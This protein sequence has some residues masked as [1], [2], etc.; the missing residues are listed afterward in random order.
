V[1]NR[2]V[3]LFFPLAV[4]LGR[5]PDRAKHP[6]GRRSAPARCDVRSAAPVYGGPWLLDVDA[7]RARRW[8]RRGLVPPPVKE[9]QPGPESGG[10]G[11]Y[12][13][14]QSWEV[15]GTIVH[16]RVAAALPELRGD[17]R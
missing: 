2:I 15:P 16:P 6:S 13:P 10:R 4:L 7:G 12:F 14:P 3:H 17:V 5:Q 9:W 11:V 8:G 1:R